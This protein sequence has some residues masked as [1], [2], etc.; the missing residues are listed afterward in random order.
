M[1]QIINADCRSLAKS[2]RA[3]VTRDLRPSLVRGRNRCG[4]F[5]WRDEHIRLEIVDTLIEPVVHSP[6]SIVRS[7]E[8]VHLQRPT[9]RPFEVWSRR[10]N[11]WPRCLT[12]IDLLLQLEISIGFEATG[13]SNRRDPF[14]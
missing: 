14:G 9:S 8:L 13:C 11:L 1:F 10:M 12:P 5:R 3:Q 6:G 7:V 4:K 2:D